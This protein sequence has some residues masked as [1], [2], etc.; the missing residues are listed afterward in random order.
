MSQFFSRLI[1]LS[2]TLLL[3][4]HAAEAK[5]VVLIHG[6]MGSPESWEDSGINTEL[7]RAGW[8]RGGIVI[9]DTNEFFGGPG[10]ESKNVA[11]SVDLPWMRPLD[12]QVA[13]LDHAIA[14]IKRKRP[15]E[16]LTLVGHS[17]G[18]VV[19]RMWLVIY[20][21]D[22]VDR[23]ITIAS[24]H[25]GT[26]RAVDALRLTNP[27]FYPV[28]QVRNF[29]GG[30]LYNTVRRSRELVK[31]LTPPDRGNALGW[32]NTQPHPKIEYISI[33]RED[34]FGLDRDWIVSANSQDLT[35]IPEL[36]NH[37]KTL[38]VSTGHV[39]ER[40]DGVLLTDLLAEPARKKP[41]RP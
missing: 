11:Y 35:R 9:P 32:L 8:S 16:V 22:Q 30:E 17:V 10:A 34:A 33:V 24:P 28:D 7:S 13:E 25:A 31:D 1:A 6:Y 4:C 18:G 20:G 40:R 3:T 12:V 2:F 29:F 21:A 36:K 38:A 39:L 41:I 14:M 15:N 26:T 19:A 37:A 5:V 23:L 27:T